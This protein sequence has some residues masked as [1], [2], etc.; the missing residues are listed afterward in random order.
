MTNKYAEGYPRARYYG[1]CECVDIVEDLARDRLKEIFG[2]KHANVQPHSGAQANMAVYLAKLNVGDTVLGMNL[3]HGGHLSHG[4][5]V[6]SS[7][8]L[9]NFIPY[10]VDEK[11]GK[12]DYEEVER[13]AI[14][15]KPKLILAGAS[16]Y[17]REIDFKN[18]NP[19]IYRIKDFNKLI[20]SENLFARKFDSRIDK[21]I[22]NEIFN[23]LL[24]VEYKQT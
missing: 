21:E 23:Y 9:Y 13:L 20:N 10:G 17:P 2:A 7:G 6:N 15:H 5:K 16:A 22:I 24:R 18:G 4:S 11:T 1:G 14:E 8:K 3:S 12:I 19:Y